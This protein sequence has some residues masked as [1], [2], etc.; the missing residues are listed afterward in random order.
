MERIYFLM[1]FR[2]V[3][4]W[5]HALS[6][7][8]KLFNHALTYAPLF[9]TFKKLVWVL[10]LVD[11]WTD[12]VQLLELTL[13][14][15]RAED[16]FQSSDLQLSCDGATKATDDTKTVTLNKDSQCKWKWVTLRTETMQ[17]LRYSEPVMRL[18]GYCAVTHWAEHV[19]A[20]LSKPWTQTKGQIK[21]RWC[22]N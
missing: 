15:K 8:L 7:R 12:T 9:L 16:V 19:P 14:A 4:T 20:S 18:N 17:T 22:Q 6:A 10:L 11:T 13:P 1:L 21:C 5:T 3:L 2:K